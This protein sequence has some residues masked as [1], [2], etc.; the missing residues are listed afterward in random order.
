VCD[1]FRRAVCIVL[2]PAIL[3]CADRPLYLPQADGP[4][5]G[6]ADFALPSDLANESDLANQLDLA[7]AID[8]AKEIDLANALDLDVRRDLSFDLAA[9]RDL[10]GPSDLA[11]T[12][13]ACGCGRDCASLCPLGQPCRGDDDCLSNACDSLSSTC[14]ADPC[15]DHH[16]D[17]RE[18]D[19]DCGDGICRPCPVLWHC[20]EDANCAAPLYCEHATFLPFSYCSGGQC[21]TSFCT[22][23]APCAD[24]VKDGMESDVDCGGQVCDACLSGQHCTSG[25]DCQAGHVCTGGICLGVSCTS[26]GF[27]CVLCANGQTCSVAADCA[28]GVCDPGSH[29]CDAPTCSDRVKNGNETDVDC[30]GSCAPC[31][32]GG[33]CFADSDCQSQACDGINHRCVADACSDHRRDGAESDVDCG[34]GACAIC[35]LGHD[36]NSDDDCGE[37]RCDP[38]R[39]ICAPPWCFDGRF[40]GNESDLD[41]GGPCAGCPLGGGCRVDQDCASRA[42]DALTL[43]CVADSCADHWEEGTE[44]SVDCGGSCGSCTV[45]EEC[46]SD[47]DCGGFACDLST[48]LCHDAWC[49]DGV[50]DHGESDVDC[51]VG[52]CVQ[53]ALGKKCNLDSDCLSNACDAQSGVC[54]S[55]H[56]RDHRVDAEESDVD[57]GGSVCPACGHGQACR[58]SFDCMA[59][60]PCLN[61]F[62]E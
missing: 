18:S 48:H 41:C 17:G 51:G 13:L 33:V 37:S 27:D 40:D 29:T 31:A 58:W 3:S 28:S 25:F 24:G 19:I 42:C 57:C 11:S 53:C 12:D 56:C 45:A 35:P 5:L 6:F 52:A 20:T 15:D 61:L 1:R 9:A 26:C 39:L 54:I 30:G 7:N 60:H 34:G 16:R 21:V 44:T 22:Q 46:Q 55:D 36:C 10:A 59:G 62:C 32:L 50:Q 49:S 2:A 43:R 4:D 14:V 47:A 38:A 8:F 23:F